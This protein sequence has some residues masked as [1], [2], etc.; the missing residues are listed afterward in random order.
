MAQSAP[1]TKFTADYAQIVNDELGDDA[2][3]LLASALKLRKVDEAVRHYS[4]YFPDQETVDVTGAGTY[5]YDLPTDWVIGFSSIVSVEFPKGDQTPTI[6]KLGR[7][8]IYYNSAVDVSKWRI[9]FLDTTPTANDTIRITFTKPHKVTTTTSTIPD[10]HWEAVAALA[11]GLCLYTMAGRS[12][13]QRD[14]QVSGDLFRFRSV[15]RDYQDLAE[16]I[17]REKYAKKL[18]ISMDGAGFAT[19]IVDLDMNLTGGI[20]PFGRPGV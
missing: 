10:T 1:G 13:S 17:V 18:G 15:A 9:R 3:N 12:L 8:R 2:N 4:H 5:D 11:T 16:T 14:S 6:L 7:V 20:S 19:E